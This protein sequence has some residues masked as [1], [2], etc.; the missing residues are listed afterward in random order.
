MSQIEHLIQGPGGLHDEVGGLTREGQTPHGL[1]DLQSQ[2]VLDTELLRRA[3][4]TIFVEAQRAGLVP[5]L[6]RLVPIDET[7]HSEIHVRRMEDQGRHSVTLTAIMQLSHHTA[8]FGVL[9]RRRLLA[10]F[11]RLLRSACDKQGANQWQ[12]PSQ[13][14]SPV[15]W[16]G[17]DN[18]WRAFETHPAAPLTYSAGTPSLMGTG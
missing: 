6:S 11:R 4:A 1:G 7:T 18:T 15:V 10:F 16:D 8:G 3:R 14:S 17:V 12:K 9:I 13:E 5:P 2:A